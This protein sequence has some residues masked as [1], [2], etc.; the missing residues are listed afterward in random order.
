MTTEQE[1]EQ[2]LQ[3]QAV[4]PRITLLEVEQNIKDIAYYVI[5]DVLTICVIQLQNGFT[6]TGESACASPENFNKEIGE[7][8]ARKNAVSKIWMLM[9]YEL[10]SKLHKEQNSNFFTRLTDEYTQLHERTQKLARFLESV[11]FTDLPDE[12]Q[13]VLKVQ[14][15]VMVKYRECLLERL[16]LSRPE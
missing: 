13:R 7:E 3:K 6:V 9:G 14:F 12:Q 1:L 4:A 8:I 10:K 15:D 16:S 5:F 2:R 11:A